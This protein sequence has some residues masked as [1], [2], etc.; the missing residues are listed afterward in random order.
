MSIA[1]DS[2]WGPFMLTVDI[3]FSTVRCLICS[4]PKRLQPSFPV[5][6]DWHQAFDNDKWILLPSTTVLEDIREFIQ[7]VICVR[8]QSAPREIPNFK[9]KVSSP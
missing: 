2:T 6:A 7:S 5:K 1:L 9:A 8:K 3:I 4:K